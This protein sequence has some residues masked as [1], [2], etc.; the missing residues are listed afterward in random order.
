MNSYTPEGTI[1]ATGWGLGEV[2]PGTDLSAE[3]VRLAYLGR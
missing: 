3:V 1:E 2:S